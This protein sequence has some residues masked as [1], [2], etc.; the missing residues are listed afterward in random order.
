[1]KWADV[2]AMVQTLD[3]PD[4]TR[5]DAATLS[6]ILR[7][8]P[9]L[10]AVTETYKSLGG[11]KTL[12]K[13]C[14]VEYAKSLQSGECDV[15]RL[16]AYDRAP[17]KALRHACTAMSAHHAASNDDVRRW[18]QTSKVML[19]EVDEHVFDMVDRLCHKYSLLTPILL[20]TLSTTL[21]ECNRLGCPCLPYRP[22]P[23]SG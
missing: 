7:S 14:L 19:Q 12:V 23:S 3:A 11:G 15:C 2:V 22:S 6:Q 18:A 21:S 20:T 1:M 13:A 10:S 4:A 8:P 5:R 17:G 16:Q 9:V